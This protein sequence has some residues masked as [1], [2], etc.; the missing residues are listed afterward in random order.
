MVVYA[1]RIFNKKGVYDM[2]QLSGVFS[3]Y[4][5]I[6][7]LAIGLYMV[8]IQG[9]NLIR[10]DHMNREGRFSKIV[11]WIYIIVGLLGFVI[12]FI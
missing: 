8:F 1:G 2:S 6:I 10:V 7:M 5:D 4:I 11:G 3:I 12:T 9:N